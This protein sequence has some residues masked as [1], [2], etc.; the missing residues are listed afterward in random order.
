MKKIFLLLCLLPFLAL[1]QTGYI[2]TIAGNGVTGHTGDGG[3]AVAASLN[4]PTSTVED[5]AGNLYIAE[6]EGHVIR[7]VT[8]AGVISTIAGDGTMGYSGDGGPATAARINNPFQL[9]LDTIGNL[10]FCEEN[11][12]IRKISTGGIISTIAGTG[13]YGFSGDGGPATAATMCRPKGL[14]TDNRGNLFFADFENGKIRKIDASGTITTVAGRLG[15]G[16]SGDGGPATAAYFRGPSYLLFDHA[17]NLIV[18]DSGNYCIRK[19]DVFGTITTIGG[20]GSPGY[21]GDGGPATAAQFNCAFGIA[22]DAAYNLFIADYAN[23]VIRSISPTGIVNTVYGTGRRAYSGDGGPATAACFNRPS[24]CYF[25]HFGKLLISDYYNNAIRQIDVLPAHASDSMG[26]NVYPACTDVRYS[27]QVPRYIAGSSIQTYFGDGT[28]S[29]DSVP[30]SGILNVNHSYRSPGTFNIK[31]IYR[32]GGRSVDSLTYGQAFLFCNVVDLSVF[33]DKNVNCRVDSNETLENYPFKVLVDSNGV[34]VDT[35]SIISGIY[36]YLLGSYGDVYSFRLWD[37]ADRINVVCPS[38]GIITDTLNGTVTKFG[39]FG[40]YCSTPSATDFELDRVYSLVGRH[41]QSG[42]LVVKNRSCEPSTGS[43]VFSY[44][45]R[46]RLSSVYPSPTSAD[47][48]YIT[49]NFGYLG[50]DTNRFGLF[51]YDLEITGAWLTPGDSVISSAVTV[52]TIRDIDLS[53]NSGNYI[54]TAKASYDPNEME[55][56][57]SCFDDGSIPHKLRYTLKFE[58]TGNDTA[59]NIHVMDTLSD[60]LNMRTMNIEFSSHQMTVSYFRDSVGHN[61]VKFDFPNINLRDSSHFG[62]CDGFLVYTINTRPGLTNGTNINSKAGIYFDDNEVVM[63][64]TATT[65]VGCPVTT[66]KQ[67]QKGFSVNIYPNPTTGILNIDIDKDAFDSYTITNV[68]G[69]ELFSADISGNH[70]RV[71]INY[72]PKGVYFAILRGKN[73]TEVRKFVKE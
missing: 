10:Y 46:Y 15:W 53:N 54:D 11:Q 35:L 23:S 68:L 70:N 34:R 48:G 2:R 51:Y 3:A 62:E 22:E 47:T 60:Y 1:A 45:R 61:I 57:T 63:T 72:L 14:A 40:V 58:N 43:L 73:G 64:N 69:S 49:W 38:S 65:T 66:V 32:V 67:V 6:Y 42:C 25:D 59:H 30:A 19:I 13:A 36:Y 50:L 24:D 52:P 31:H 16:Y 29:T 17:G 41:H 4:R 44:D 55:V 28:N 18:T 12:R 56:N 71:D 9:V 27:V 21:S 26:V 37:T 20:T 5:T 39:N 8:A 7:K 33:Y